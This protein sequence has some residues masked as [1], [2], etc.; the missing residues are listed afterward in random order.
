MPIT[1]IAD[2]TEDALHLRDLLDA[3]LTKVEDTFT[4]YNVPMP[5]RRYWTLG[6]PSI[7]CEQIVVSF[8][9]MY[10]GPPGDQASQ[11]MRCNVPKSAVM[12]VS[13]AREIPVVG[14]NGRA[15]TADK[16]QAGSEISA[17]DAW[18]LMDTV[19]LFDR[20][21]DSGYGPGVIATLDAGTPEG[22]FQVVTLQL[23]MAIP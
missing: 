7:D 8:V 10:L 3:V 22:G 18:V 19:Q 15:P 4:S 12:T 2:V 1:S 17:V 5:T 11:P 9:Q 20:W 23:T 21:D 13:V 6:T 14:T 16:I